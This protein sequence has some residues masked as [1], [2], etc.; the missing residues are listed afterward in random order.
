MANP[1]PVLNDPI[2][3]P[4]WMND[5]RDP[6]GA[7]CRIKANGQRINWALENAKFERMRKEKILMAKEIQLELGVRKEV[8]RVC[9]LKA[10][11]IEAAP[12][13]TDGMPDA[14][15][16]TDPVKGVSVWMELKIA[17]FDSASNIV[18]KFRPPQKKE[19]KRLLDDGCVVLIGWAIQGEPDVFV[20]EA[21]SWVR[22]GILP[23]S[24]EGELLDE[25]W[26]RVSTADCGG[27]VAAVMKGV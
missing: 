12:G 8:R 20:T 11:W 13:G 2:L 27:G 22:N 3:D 6:D 10:R 23:D 1:E 17:K 25:W 24:C 15:I 18:M 21:G 5:N 19:I 26:A 9:G 4:E 16:V 7:V 14:F